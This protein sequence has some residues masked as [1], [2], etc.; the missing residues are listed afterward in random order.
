[1]PFLDVKPEHAMATHTPQRTDSDAD[2][3]HEIAHVEEKEVVD[4]ERTEAPHVDIDDGFDPAFVK[5]TMRKVDWRLIPVLSAMYCVSLIDRT[6]LSGAR[7][8]N[9]RHFD[10]ELGTTIGDRYSIITIMFFIPYIILE[11][12]VRCLSGPPL[13]HP[14]YKKHSPRSAFAPLV[15]VS[16]FRRL[17]SL[18]ALSWWAWAM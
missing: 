8:A 10:K 11:I 5:R 14:A 18:G 12:P 13:L 6:N 7:Q 4:V 16:G 3:K 15:L 17:C 1:M 9:D 2:S